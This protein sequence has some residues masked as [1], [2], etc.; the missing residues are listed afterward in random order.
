MSLENLRNR[1]MSA[2][3]AATATMRVRRIAPMNM[4]LAELKEVLD[5][6][7]NHPQAGD[8][9]RFYEE[10]SKLLDP[11]AVV[12]VE[13]NVVLGILDGAKIVEKSTGI[14]LDGREIVETVL[15]E[16]E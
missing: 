16:T 1:A 13:K 2:T 12:A 4:T 6:N 3:P 15:E 8:L 5:A 10:H 9:R 11:Q 7:P 14:S